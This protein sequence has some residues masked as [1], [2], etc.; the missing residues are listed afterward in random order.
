[1]GES[2]SMGAQDQAVE[3]APAVDRGGLD[4]GVGQRWDPQ[5]KEGLD[6]GGSASPN[7]RSVSFLIWLRKATSPK[8]QQCGWS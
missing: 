6:P 3:E 1:M 7:I 5:G 8:L 2:R 4:L